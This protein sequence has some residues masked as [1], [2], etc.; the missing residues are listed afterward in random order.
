MS[1]R[2][3]GRSALA[4]ACLA[5]GLASACCLGPLLLVALGVSS[6]WIGTLAVLEPYRPI[7]IGMA[8]LAM[9]FAWRR[10]FRSAIPDEPGKICTV[11]EAAKVYK[12]LFWLVAVLVLVAV[13]FPYIL[14][15]LH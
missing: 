14:S 6:A 2:K 7:F 13:C 8:L 5:A 3:Y 4:A 11:P 12:I 15:L 1:K 9:F 10:I